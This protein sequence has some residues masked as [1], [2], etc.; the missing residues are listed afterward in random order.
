MDSN[1]NEIYSRQEEFEDLLIFKIKSL[2]DKR[3]RDFDDK[4][5]TNFSKELAL[6]L[7]KEIGEFLDAVGNYKLHKTQKDGKNIKE[8][9]EEIADM[10]IFVLDM[11]LTHNMT[12]EE[13][14]KEVSKK[15]DKNFERQR[16]GY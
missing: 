9:K 2:P 13:L 3:L 14:L 7:H 12:T 16:T 11:A 1:F 4:E 5:K 6:M 10:F 8:V 15:Q